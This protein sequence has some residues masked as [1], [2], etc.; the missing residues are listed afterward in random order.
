MYLSL[1]IGVLQGALEWSRI[2]SHP[3]RVTFALSETFNLVV[4]GLLI[5]LIARRRKGWVC[6]LMIAM[7]ILGLPFSIP[8]LW[9][10]LQRPITGILSC[11]AWS[12]QIVA[13]YLVLTGNSR[14]WFIYK[15]VSPNPD[16]PLAY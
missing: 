7:F 14:E 1:G 15:F 6:W 10:S 8:A 16:R 2:G 11:S 3:A 12:A 9:R 5:W 4:F 13:L